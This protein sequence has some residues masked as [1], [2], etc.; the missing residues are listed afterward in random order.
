MPIAKS[1]I[2]GPKLV[3]PWFLAF[4]FALLPGLSAAGEWLARI[5]L[6]GGRN[7]IIGEDN[8]LAAV[9]RF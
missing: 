2:S 6:G 4:G 9:Y 1:G 7:P 3:A 8:Y 5:T